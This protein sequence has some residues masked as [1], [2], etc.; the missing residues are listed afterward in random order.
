MSLFL[1]AEHVH[2]V[3]TL[4]IYHNGF[5]GNLT[6]SV[7]YVDASVDYFDYISPANWSNTMLDEIMYI[8]DWVRGEKVHVYWLLPDTELADGIVPIVSHDEIEEMRKATK[9]HKRLL[10]FVDQTSFIRNLRPNVIKV[11]KQTT[12]N[13]SD[14]EHED[15]GHEDIG[16]GVESQHDHEE[17]GQS[18]NDT[19]SDF[20]FVDSDLDAESG[21]D[22]MFADNVDRDV[23][24]SNDQIVVAEVQNDTLLDDRDLELGEEERLSLQYKFNAFNPQIDMDRPTF[25][26]GLMFGNIEDLRQAVN[27][28]SIRERVKIRKIKNDRTRLHEVC[29]DDY[30]WMLKVGYDMQRIGGYVITAY[31]GEHRCERVYQMRALTAKFLAQKFIE[32]FMDN[33]KMDMQTFASKV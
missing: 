29:D 11:A 12:P 8:H 25:R 4:M 14:Q 26:L 22:D 1:F 20:S 27:A 2:D 16:Q 17:E 31:N 21:D 28:Y 24:D 13:D 9:D 15:I 7:E 5:F 19:D 30:P 10:I 33:Q 32:E 6:G 18:D 3:F 23:N